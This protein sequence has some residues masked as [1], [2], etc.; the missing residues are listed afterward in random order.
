MAVTLPVEVCEQIMEDVLSYDRRLHLTIGDN[1]T[2]EVLSACCLVAR[3]WLPRARFLLYT[4]VHLDADRVHQFSQCITRRPPNAHFVQHLYVDASI[5]TRRTSYGWQELSLIPL[6]LPHRLPNLVH[7]TFDEVQFLDL[8]P[9]F[10][11]HLRHFRSVRTI[12]CDGAVFTS[13]YQFT[14][15]LRSF[16]H[17]ETLESN[18]PGSVNGFHDDELADRMLHRKVRLPCLILTQYDV[19]EDP[20]SRW[21]NALLD[22]SS[23]TDITSFSLHLTLYS[24]D[25]LSF[26]LGCLGNLRH[27]VINLRQLSFPYIR[28]SKSFSSQNGAVDLPS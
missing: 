7:I 2:R 22:V 19:L 28:S 1:L 23:L 26:P 11:D 13:V 27:L 18:V 10:F 12:T 6:V 17:L 24:Q 15:L 14:Q 9:V 16:P 4:T 8:H 3:A 5:R 21:R 25:L 20:A